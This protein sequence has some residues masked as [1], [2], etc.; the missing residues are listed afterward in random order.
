MK[1]FKKLPQVS[2]SVRYRA[3]ALTMHTRV[4][5][6][7]VSRNGHKAERGGG[8]SRDVTSSPPR[9]P[10]LPL[11][12]PPRAGGGAGLKEN[13]TVFA[14]NLATKTSGGH[15]SFRQQKE[16]QQAR[17][18]RLGPSLFHTPPTRPQPTPFLRLLPSP[19]PPSYNNTAHCPLPSVR[20]QFWESCRALPVVGKRERE[21]E[22]L[23]EGGRERERK[24]EVVGGREERERETETERRSERVRER[25]EDVERERLMER[26]KRETERVWEKEIGR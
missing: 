20:W 12:P 19:P 10:P 5:V 25:G 17:N 13:R 7:L 14:K 15:K 11:R 8:K 3:R 16:R 6:V 18:F 9:L 22:R 1:K 4:R 26:E 24:W 21:R 2:S 23:R